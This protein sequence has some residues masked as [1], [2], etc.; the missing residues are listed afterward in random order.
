MTNLKKR[1]ETLPVGTLTS[2]LKQLDSFRDKT[3]LID[4]SG[5]M[6]A[7]VNDGTKW[8]IVKN[9][10]SDLPPTLRRFVFNDRC[11]EINAGY[12]PPPSGSTNMAQAFHVMKFN[13]ITKFLL[14]TDGLP[15]SKTDA[16]MAARDLDIS[17]IYIGPDP[18]PPFLKELGSLASVNM[19][20]A[21]ANKE[22]ENKIK[23]LLS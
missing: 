19:L 15:N 11:I 8:E 18:V 9:I 21:G 17:I 6:S 5:S 2:K 3:I 1:Q 12:L 20:N 16:L 14:L 4:L 22:L 10:I 7:H 23:G 13:Q